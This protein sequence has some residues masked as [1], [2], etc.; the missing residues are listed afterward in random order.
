MAD[1]LHWWPQTLSSVILQFLSPKRQGL[2][3]SIP[4]VWTWLLMVSKMRWRYAHAGSGLGKV[5]TLLLVLSLPSPWEGHAQ[6]SWLVGERHVELG[7]VPSVNPKTGTWPKT[8]KWAQPR[9]AEPFQ[10]TP[11][12]WHEQLLSAAEVLW[13]FCFP[14]FRWQWVTCTWSLF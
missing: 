14:A 13:L 7:Q 5:F 9:S 11:G 8:C 10:W 3:L 1:C 4:C 6:S 2:S 12:R